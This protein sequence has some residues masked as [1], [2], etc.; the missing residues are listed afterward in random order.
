MLNQ[1]IEQI[2]GCFSL[3]DLRDL[4]A[5]NA[6]RWQALPGDQAGEIIRVK[7]RQKAEIEYARAEREAIQAD[8]GQDTGPVAIQM[9]SHILGG[10]VNVRLW[11]DR[12]EVAG[13]EYSN[14]ELADL[15]KRGL[16]ADDLR[17]VHEVKQAFDG[18]VVEGEWGVYLQ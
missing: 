14:D 12:A 11:P 4:W 2:E 18:K 16:P 9:D 3:P 1:A 8:G 17:A 13:V 5:E 10:A 15:I 6:E 7:D